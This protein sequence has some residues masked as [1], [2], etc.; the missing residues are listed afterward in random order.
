MTSTPHDGSSRR[1]RTF[2]SA[3]FTLIELMVAIVILAVLLALAAPSFNNAS[4]SGRLNGFA[5]S[6]VAAA[7]VARS[8]AIK[9]NST[10]TVCASSDG[11]NCDNGIDWEQGW[12]VKT[13]DDVVLQQQQRLPTEFKITQSGGTAELS[14][15]P[16]VVGTSTATLTVCRSAPVGSEERVVT[17]NGTGAASVTITDTGSCP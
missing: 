5:N 10:I 7:Q 6:L 15:L 8:E 16:T 1:S 9:R 13:E 12:I 2:G 3:G 17:I 11:S 14:F 4:L